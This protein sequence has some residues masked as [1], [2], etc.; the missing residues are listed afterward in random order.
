MRREDERLRRAEQR[1]VE[2]GRGEPLEVEDVAATAEQP[3]HRQR[4]LERLQAA[5]SGRPGDPVERG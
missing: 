1:D 3:A 5:P 2:L 4:V